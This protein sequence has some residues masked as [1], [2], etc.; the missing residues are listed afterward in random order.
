MMEKISRVVFGKTFYRCNPER[1]T[2][3]KKLVC[4]YNTNAKYRD[5]SETSKKE[6]ALKIWQRAQT[7]DYS[8]RSEKIAF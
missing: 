4:R 5:C 3:C 1:N 8:P 2:E 7:K 6:C